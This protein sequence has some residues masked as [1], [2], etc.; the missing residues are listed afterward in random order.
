MTPA[1]FGIRM[2]HDV[3]FVDVQATDTYEPI[4]VVDGVTVRVLMTGSGV[5][6]AGS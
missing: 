2:V 1:A 5:F 3:A 6:A 4:F